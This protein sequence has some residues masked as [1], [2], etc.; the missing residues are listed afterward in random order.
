MTSA[1]INLVAISDTEQMAHSLADLEKALEEEL[2]FLVRDMT[3]AGQLNTRVFARQLAGVLVLAAESRL[4]N[5]LNFDVEKYRQAHG[6]TQQADPAWLTKR[7]SQ[8]HDHST[9]VW[10][11]TLMMKVCRATQNGALIPEAKAAFGEGMTALKHHLPDRVAQKLNAH[12]PQP[13][14]V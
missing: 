12:P 7:L 2:V 6:G 8:T 5:K 13:C 9:R 11:P 1:V 14:S 4:A 10:L 3:Q